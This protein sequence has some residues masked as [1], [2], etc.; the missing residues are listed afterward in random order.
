M[1][2]RDPVPIVMGL[3]LAA[4]RAAGAPLLR[5]HEGYRYEDRFK[6]GMSKQGR[7]KR[8]QNLAWRLTAREIKIN[9]P[10]IDEYYTKAKRPRC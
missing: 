9:S 8:K 4:F 2:A 1:H 5:N 3:R 6:C 7:I 10:E